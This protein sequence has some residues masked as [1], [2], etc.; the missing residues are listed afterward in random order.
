MGPAG[1]CSFLPADGGKE[2]AVTTSPVCA[3]RIG[4]SGSSEKSQKRGGLLRERASVTFAL[5]E[6][7]KAI[8]PIAMMCRVLGVSSSGFYAWERRPESSRAQED[9]RL[10]VLV[11]APFEESKHRYGSPRIHVAP[12]RTFRRRRGV[13]KSIVGGCSS[14]ASPRAKC[15]GRRQLC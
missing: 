6:A 11:R 1:P 3:R 5:I 7:T 8:F 15:R 14:Y 4:S 13:G 12:C 9:R 2:L 10:R